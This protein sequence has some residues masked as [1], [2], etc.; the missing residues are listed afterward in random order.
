VKKQKKAD[1][2]HSVRNSLIP[3]IPP[4]ESR[5]DVESSAQMFGFLPDWLIADDDSD[6]PQ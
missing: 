3:L 5:P 6:R 2:F 1:I 4:R